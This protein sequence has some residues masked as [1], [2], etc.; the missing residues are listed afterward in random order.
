MKISTR[1]GALGLPALPKARTYDIA[2]RQGAVIREQHRDAFRVCCC[3]T[4][5]E[6]RQR[7]P[8]AI[9][10]GAAPRLSRRSRPSEV[11]APA[12][13]A[14]PIRSATALHGEADLPF[15]AKRR[16]RLRHGV[17]MSHVDLGQ[18]KWPCSARSV[19]GRVPRRGVGFGRPGT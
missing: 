14:F 1:S 17:A 7:S 4:R 5:S 9:S 10:R 8:T 16:S 6:E 12:P 2:R 15:L 11:R 18:F 19:E 3:G 13:C